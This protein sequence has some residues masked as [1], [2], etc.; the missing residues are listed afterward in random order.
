MVLNLSNQEWLTGLRAEVGTLPM[1]NN[2]HTAHFLSPLPI[3]IMQE[4]RG[5]QT[6]GRRYPGVGRATTRFTEGKEKQAWWAIH[7]SSLS[8]SPSPPLPLLPFSLAP[9][10][11]RPAKYLG[12][13]T[14]TGESRDGRRDG[15][16]DGGRDGWPRFRNLLR[17]EWAEGRIDKGPADRTDE[18]AVFPTP[19]QTW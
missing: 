14:E 1:T 13:V 19:H 6:D 7:L 18:R 8:S 12:A 10:T 16:R 5:G 2:V 9:S 3:V 15:R 4:P 11:H 17:H